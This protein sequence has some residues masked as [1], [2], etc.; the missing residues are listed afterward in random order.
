MYLEFVCLYYDMKI[1][2]YSG[3]FDPPTKGHIW[4]MERALDLFDRVH[5]MIG[6]HAG[7][8]PLFSWLHRVEMIKACLPDK[9]IT[10]GPLSEDIVT[11]AH[12]IAELY[13]HYDGKVSLIRGMRDLKD[14]DY[15]ET[16]CQNIRDRDENLHTLFLIPPKELVDISSS[17]VKERWRNLSWE[18]TENL[19]P[20]AVFKFI[21]K[22]HEEYA[23]AMR[24]KIL[25][26][27]FEQTTAGF[28]P[29]PS[30]SFCMW[31]GKTPSKYLAHFEN[32]TYE[33][34]PFARMRR[35]FDIIHRNGFISYAQT[36]TADQVRELLDPYPV[37][38]IASETFYLKEIPIDAATPTGDRYLPQ[39]QSLGPI[40]V[41]LKTEELADYDAYDRL[42]KVVVIEG[43]HRWLDAKEAGYKTILAWVGEKALKELG[44]S[45][46]S[47]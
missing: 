38:V 30:E 34:D 24:P 13:K 19:L 4:V 10:V 25:T 35:F 44:L 18:T 23:E 43:K 17:Y 15:E 9:P 22:H 39:S 11:Y 27:L 46:E 14:F 5:I 33:T 12:R 20:P 21:S 40:L 28:A 45:A 41:D 32:A 47:T 7:K 31:G 1:G 16:I 6:S 2:I 26:S 8:K 3:C 42:G 37:E 36:V 29:A